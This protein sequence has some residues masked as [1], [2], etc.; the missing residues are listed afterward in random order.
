M[1]KEKKR[2]KV[3]ALRTTVNP[4]EK[5]ER[6]RRKKKKKKKSAGLKSDFLPQLWTQR[7]AKR[8]KNFR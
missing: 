4:N 5:S 2:I 6:R 3:T 1:R 7:E 8:E